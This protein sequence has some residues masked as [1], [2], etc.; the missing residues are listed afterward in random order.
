M[1][2]VLH[3]ELQG[4]VLKLAQNFH[5]RWDKEHS[6]AYT[7][8]DCLVAG[9]EAKRRSKEYSEETRNR[10]AFEKELGADPTI[11]LR[12]ADMLKLCKKFGIGYSNAGFEQKIMEQAEKDAA[13]A[14]KTA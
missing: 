13:A 4:A 11:V 6:L 14:Q 1:D 10:K 12:P 8:E 7:I 2:N 5:D 9:I 3:I